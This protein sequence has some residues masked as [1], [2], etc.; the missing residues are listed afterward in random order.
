MRNNFQMMRAMSDYTR[1]A[2]KDRVSRLLDFSRRINQ[3]SRSCTTLQSFGVELDRD[4]LR[5]EGRTL[6][7]EKMVF[8]KNA[9]HQNDQ[10][11]DWTPGVI[12]NEMY[13]VESLTRWGIVFP[14][15][16]ERELQEFLKIFREVARGIKV[17]VA[18]PRMICLENDRLTT[19][20]GKL[21]EFCS[22]D[23]K[24]VMIVLPTNSADRYSAVKSVTYIRF[25]IPSQVIV[26]RTMQPK[27]GNW[28]GVKS[29][30]TKVVLQM[31]TKLGGAPWMINMPLS[32]CMII[33]M[34]NV[35]I[36]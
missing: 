14:T 30:A 1:M 16:C 18:D 7:Q 27:K 20:C 21:E 23:P 15:R 29:I 10:R 8:G 2:P 36:V 11:V 3:T 31:I 26:S 25:G 17:E 34:L 4:L 19:Y 12:R 33:G 5:V 24:F 35:K 22:K 32:G 6:P 13:W 28:A 9:T